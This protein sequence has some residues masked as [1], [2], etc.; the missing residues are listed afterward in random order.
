MNPKVPNVSAISL[1]SR[2]SVGPVV[3]APKKNKKVVEPISKVVVEKEYV[4][5][6]PFPQRLV[7][8]KKKWMR[9]KG[10]RKYSTCSGK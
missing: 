10:T 6:I 7:K 2:K 1:R 5:P 3:P 4:S 8:T 9:K